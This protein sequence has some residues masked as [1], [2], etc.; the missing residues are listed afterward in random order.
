MNLHRCMAIATLSVMSLTT[1]CF[2]NPTVLTVYT[3]YLSHETLASY[4]VN[5]P[6]PR[7]NN[8]S[9]GQRLIIS[10]SVPKNYLSL[11]NLHLKITVR[12][13]TR[14]EM[15]ELVSLRKKSGTFVYTLL[16]EDYIYTRG[17]LTYKVDLIGGDC[18][19]EEWRHQ[20]WTDL[21]TLEGGNGSQSVQKEDNEAEEGED[22]WD[23]DLD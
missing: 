6:D 1:S 20:I 5:T 16:N 9:I 21:I 4:H 10:W 22:D 23:L 14:E 11:D 13:R 8:P 19:I 18:L 2:K 7:L 15:V 3:D 17:I 12:F